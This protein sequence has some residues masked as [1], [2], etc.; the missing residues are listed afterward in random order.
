MKRTARGGWRPREERA[1]LLR[2]A[3]VAL[4]VLGCRPA[5]GV[6]AIEAAVERYFAGLGYTVV[7][8]SMGEMRQ[9]PVRERE[10]M[11]PLTYVVEIP[12]LVLERVSAPIVAA[13]P[14]GARL[15]FSGVTL[16]LQATSNAAPS[17]AVWEVSQVVGV[18]LR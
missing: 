13:V 15:R 4:L 16:K 18:D 5:P 1:A 7:Q 11:A 8:L 6:E 10:Y 9:N 14:R 17:G 2:G 3:V 12:S